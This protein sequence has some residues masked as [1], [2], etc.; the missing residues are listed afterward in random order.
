MV[1]ICASHLS[2]LC[3]STR[4]QLAKIKVNFKRGQGKPKSITLLIYQNLFSGENSEGY[5]EPENQTVFSQIK[6]KEFS[7]VHAH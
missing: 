4:Q 7:L 1:P 5:Q 6:Q 3:S 2:S